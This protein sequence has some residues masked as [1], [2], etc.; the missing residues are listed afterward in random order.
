MNYKPLNKPG[1]H[2]TGTLR[3]LSAADIERILG[4]PANVKDDPYKVKYSWG[5][6][7][8]GKEFGVWSYKGSE[9]A[10]IFSVYGDPAILADIFGSKNLN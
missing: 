2:K 9:K 3:N 7:C 6:E 1:S 10:N 5:F 8:E 4:F